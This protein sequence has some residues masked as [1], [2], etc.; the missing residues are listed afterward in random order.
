VTGVLPKERVQPP[1]NRPDAVVPTPLKVISQVT[2]PR[3]PRRK[4]RPDKE[5]LN[6]LNLK[7]HVLCRDY[8]I[9]HQALLGPRPMDVPKVLQYSNSVDCGPLFSLQVLCHRLR[10]FHRQSWART[11][12]A[13]LEAVENSLKNTFD[14]FGD[15]AD[16]ERIIYSR[17]RDS[18]KPETHSSTS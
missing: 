14:R 10:S 17:I 12:R 11:E 1:E 13:R 6:R 8:Q 16:D 9:Y 7:G 5:L 15:Y 4:G 2:H 3:D 18:R